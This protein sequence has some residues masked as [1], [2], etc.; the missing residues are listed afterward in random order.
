MG[1]YGTLLLAKPTAVT[2]PAQ[3]QVRPAFG[4]GFATPGPWGNEMGLYDL[5]EGWQ[6]VAVMPFCTERLRLSAGVESLVA[7][8]AAPALAGYVSESSCAHIEG[9]TPSGLAIS[10]HLPNTDEPCGYQHLD[11]RPGRIDPHLAL[12]VLRTW[13]T[14]AGRT[15]STEVVATVVAHTGDGAPLMEDA[16]LAL[17]TGLGFPSGTE[18]LPV[19]NPKDFVFADF[20][21]VARMADIRAAGEKYMTSRSWPVDPDMKATPKDLDYLRYRDLLWSSVY[22]GGATREELLAQHQQLAARWQEP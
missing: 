15:P 2:L 1:Y 3:P 6:R 14:E 21:R 9:R 12:E 17:F 20:Q 7:A 8:T 19:I 5:G 22:G 16:V 18:I 13:A 4:S 11:G 10:L